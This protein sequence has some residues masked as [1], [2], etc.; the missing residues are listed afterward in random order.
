VKVDVLGMQDDATNVFAASDHFAVLVTGTLHIP[1]REGHANAVLVRSATQPRM[2]SSKTEFGTG[3]GAMT[4]TRTGPRT[5]TRAGTGTMPGTMTGTMTRT[6]KRTVNAPSTLSAPHP[7]P[8]R[9]A[10]VAR[11]ATQAQFPRSMTTGRVNTT[12]RAEAT[13]S[14]RWAA[15]R[16][17][18]TVTRNGTSLATVPLQPS[19]PKTPPPVGVWHRR[20]TVAARSLSN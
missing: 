2:S 17:N 14:A 12:S 7:G 1:R 6:G 18:S 10:W 8:P 16:S 9:M 15:K 5:G 11:N 3:T 20:R 13:N 4:R 19:P